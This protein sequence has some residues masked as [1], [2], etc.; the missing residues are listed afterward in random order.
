MVGVLSMGLETG[1]SSGR[2]GMPARSWV[3]CLASGQTDRLLGSPLG[4]DH[5]N[6]ASAG[7]M[8]SLPL[9]GRNFSASVTYLRKLQGKRYVVYIKIH[10]MFIAASFN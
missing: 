8:D 4:D 2:G 3:I 7:R 6:K 10:R 1:E 5:R 9:A